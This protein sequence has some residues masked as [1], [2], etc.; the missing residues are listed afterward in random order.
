MS[1]RETGPSSD[2]DASEG[3]WGSGGM[4]VGIIKRLLVTIGFDKSDVPGKV[5][6]KGGDLAPL[7]SLC[8]VYQFDF[9]EK[10]RLALRGRGL[11]G[12]S[13]PRYVVKEVDQYN[14]ILSQ[15]CAAIHAFSKWTVVAC[16][17]WRVVFNLLL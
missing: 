13:K 6:C 7:G 8:V 17:F 5:W 2:C 14:A 9:W 16:C 15:F 11:G 12:A 10:P 3:I 1:L 4:S